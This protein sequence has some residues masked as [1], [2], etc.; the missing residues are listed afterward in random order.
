MFMIGMKEAFLSNKVELIGLIE[1]ELRKKKIPYKIKTV[2][3]GVLSRTT[4]TFIGRAGQSYNDL[5]IMYY[6]YSKPKYVPE[7]K[8]IANDCLSKANY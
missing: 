1:H 4:G 6:I 2:N 5:D 8:S 7:I 3:S